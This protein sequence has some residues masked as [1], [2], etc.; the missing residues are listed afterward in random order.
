M[1]NPYLREKIIE[2]FCSSAG[3]YFQ[4]TYNDFCFGFKTPERSVMYTYSTVVKNRRALC[5]IYR[6]IETAFDTLRYDLLFGSIIKIII[7]LFDRI[8]TC[9]SYCY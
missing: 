6:L 9:R 1:T 3:N 8:Y 7:T 4:N 2:N 5:I